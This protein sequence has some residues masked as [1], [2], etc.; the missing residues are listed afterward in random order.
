MRIAHSLLRIL[1]INEDRRRLNERTK[2]NH[3]GSPNLG[4]AKRTTELEAEH[5]HKTDY[6]MWGKQDG[7]PNSLSELKI[8]MS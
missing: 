7:S 8:K 4:Q 5:A 1:M 6:Q 2:G 3:N